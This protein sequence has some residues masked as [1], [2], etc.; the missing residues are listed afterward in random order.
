MEKKIQG[1]ISM[2][3]FWAKIEGMGL[4]GGGRIQRV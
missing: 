3:Y 4:T 2:A 1:K